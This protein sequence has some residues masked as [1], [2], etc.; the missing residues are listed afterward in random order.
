MLCRDLLT[1]EP[2]KQR[3]VFGTG[4]MP[5]KPPAP[6]S[7]RG[8]GGEFVQMQGLH[9]REWKSGYRADFRA[10]PFQMWR[11]V[12]RFRSRREERKGIGGRLD[13]ATQTRPVSKP[14]SNHP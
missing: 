8:V 11:N 2:R 7:P 1:N 12:E 9:P 5:G 4:G 13:G 6:T 10:A 14:C 3:C